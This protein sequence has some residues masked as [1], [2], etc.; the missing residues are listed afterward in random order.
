MG[1]SPLDDGAGARPLPDK[2][3]FTLRPRRG[4]VRL[5]V[6][7]LWAYRELLFFLTLRDIQVRYKQTLLG[8]AWAVQGDQFDPPLARR[9]P[10]MAGAMRAGPRSRTS[11][12]SAS[13]ERVC[14]RSLRSRVP[15]RCPEPSASDFA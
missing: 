8:A 6:R 14:G 10:G 7:E 3:L 12:I 11:H 15:P 1:H 5:N 9:L 4:W 13:A 2:P